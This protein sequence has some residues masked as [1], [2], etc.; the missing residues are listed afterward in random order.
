M[1]GKDPQGLDHISSIARLVTQGTQRRRFWGRRRAR[2][3]PLFLS[4][5]LPPF[6]SSRLCVSLSP[7]TWARLLLFSRQNEKTQREED[8]GE[9]GEPEFTH[10][11]SSTSLLCVLASLRE[12]LPPPRG[13]GCCW[14]HARTPREEGL[15]EE[16]KP[17]LIYSFYLLSSPLRVSLS[18]QSTPRIM[19]AGGP[20]TQDAPSHFSLLTPNSSL[21]HI[22]LCVLASS[23]EPLHET[24]SRP[25]KSSTPATSASSP[26]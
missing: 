16:G 2:I 19:R 3:H 20:R 23:R 26:V 7:P 13:P 6:A 15:G 25:V 8:F 24:A 9:E 10:S 14:S 22:P 12:P 18:S 5:P 4:L 17:R 1:D 21:L 11:F